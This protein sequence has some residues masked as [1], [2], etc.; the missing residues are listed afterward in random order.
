MTAM[1]TKPKATFPIDLSAYQRITLD[2]SSE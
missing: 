1:Q 2:P